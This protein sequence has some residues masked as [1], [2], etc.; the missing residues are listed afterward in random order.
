MDP[1]KGQIYTFIRDCDFGD[2]KTQPTKAY[3]NDMCS[4]GGF[5]GSL[6]KFKPG[7]KLTIT[8]I[9]IY[10]KRLGFHD[11]LVSCS[12]I[13]PPKRRVGWDYREKILRFPSKN[14]QELLDSG[15][16][17]AEKREKR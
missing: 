3:T 4:M 5:Y 8:Q 17:R 11:I 16:L 15:V 14:F 2:P 1:K 9:D 12:Y 6:A 7:D 10:N 13:S